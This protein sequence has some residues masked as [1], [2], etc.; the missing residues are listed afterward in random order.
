MKKSNV[1][2]LALCL[3]AATLA[4]AAEGESTLG[5]ATTQTTVIQAGK[6]GRG[7]RQKAGLGAARLASLKNMPLTDEQKTQVDEIEKF[8]KDGFKGV[9]EQMLK[10]RQD[11]GSTGTLELRSTMS[12]SLM[13]LDLDVNNKIDAMLTPEQKKDLEERV[14]QARTM[15]TRRMN[16]R[17]TSA[18]EEKTE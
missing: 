4:F 18:P 6:A 2:T 11:G 15:T 5:E 1:L 3:G 16:D 12:K 14:S 10:L 7:T 17:G 13:K 9:Q 8:W